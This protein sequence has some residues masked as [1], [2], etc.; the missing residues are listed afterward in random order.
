MSAVREWG[1]VYE[2]HP[3]VFTIRRP[4]HIDRLRHRDF[5]RLLAGID[6]RTVLEAGCG[7]GQDALFLASLGRD[8]TALDAHERP[9]RNLE[10]AA[11]GVP[12]RTVQGDL[13]DPPLDAESFDLV[14][15]SG[16]V[17]HLDE[18]E[19]LATIRAM[20]RL[21]R[22]GGAVAIAVPNGRHPLAP[23]WQWLID[24]GTDHRSF[25]L[26]ERVVSFE[27]L[28]RDLAAAGCRVVR[29]LPIDPWHTLDLY[30]SWLPMR[31]AAHLAERARLPAP[32]LFATRLAVVAVRDPSARS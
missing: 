5:P 26:A 22:P 27:D 30:P 19:R 9:L 13:L 14:F 23:I 31:A 25:D 24:H 6:A 18:A 11:L 7:S 10:E 12:L 29:R 16:V 15:N 3:R 1:R 20:A 17:E 2:A 32:R 4:H 8:V 28:E 21:A